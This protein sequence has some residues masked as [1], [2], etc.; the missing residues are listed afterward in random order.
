MSAYTCMRTSTHVWTHFIS[1]ELAQCYLAS[2]SSALIWTHS[3]QSLIVTFTKVYRISNLVFTLTVHE[4]MDHSVLVTH[5]LCMLHEY[6]MWSRFCWMDQCDSGAVWCNH[7]KPCVSF[8]CTTY[9]YWLTVSRYK[10]DVFWNLAKLSG[11]LHLVQTKTNN[12]HYSTAL[13]R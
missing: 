3:F 4:K 2:I 8:S 10:L 13:L 6:K 7:G 12:T 9:L 5:F 11:M 1:F